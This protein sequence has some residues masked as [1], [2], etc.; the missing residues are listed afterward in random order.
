MD[1]TPL[2][3]NSSFVPGTVPIASISLNL[4]DDPA[5]EETEF[6]SLRLFSDDVAVI[7]RNDLFNLTTLDNDCKPKKESK[8]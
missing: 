7:I 2:V 1:Y 4:V 3:F 8:F 5:V 6:L